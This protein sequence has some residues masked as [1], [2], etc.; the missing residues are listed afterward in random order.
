MTSMLGAWTRKE[1][2]KKQVQEELK[3]IEDLVIKVY[4]RWELWVIEVEAMKYKIVGKIYDD[5]V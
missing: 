5:M 3:A 1:E 4:K 2:Y